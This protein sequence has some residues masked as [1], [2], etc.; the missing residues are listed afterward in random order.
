MTKQSLSVRAVFV[1]HQ[2]H[3]ESILLRIQ[4]FERISAFSIIISEH[5]CQVNFLTQD[6]QY[7]AINRI[8]TNKIDI[9]ALFHL[10]SS[11]NTS[12]CLFKIQHGIVKRI[13]NHSA[14]CCQCDARTTRGNLSYKHTALFVILK[15]VNL[16]VAVLYPATYNRITVLRK[17]LSCF[18]LIFR[19]FPAFCFSVI[20]CADHKKRPFFIQR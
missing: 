14:C 19:A 2:P 7:F 9:M 18:S 4:A 11:M 1:C 20:R 12:L 5:L 6:I 15:S 8:L 13:K 10:S 17:F 3:D 16:T